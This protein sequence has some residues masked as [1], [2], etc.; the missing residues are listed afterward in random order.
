MKM[1]I[2]RLFDKSFMRFLLVGVSNTILS[3]ILMFVLEDL[4]YWGSTAIAYIAGAV[5]SFFLNRSF[6]FKSKEKTGK[7]AIKFAMNVLLCY[8]IAYSLAQPFVEW[9]F[10]YTSIGGA[11]VERITKLFGMAFYTLINYFG[12]RFFAFGTPEKS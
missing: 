1:K 5:L 12:Q 6:T 4:G 11:W 9:I 8:V 10:S 3:A 2:I 7:S